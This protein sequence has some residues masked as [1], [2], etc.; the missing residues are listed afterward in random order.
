MRPGLAGAIEAGPVVVRIG[1]PQIG[2][3]GVDGVGVDVDEAPAGG[4][5]SVDGRCSVYGDGR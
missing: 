5:V 4:S 2:Q 1:A 3:I